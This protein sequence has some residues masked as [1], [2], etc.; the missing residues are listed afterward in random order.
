MSAFARIWPVPRVSLRASLVT[1]CI[2]V[3][4]PRGWKRECSQGKLVT[5]YERMPMPLLRVSARKLGTDGAA[6]SEAVGEVYEDVKEIPSRGGTITE[7]HTSACSR[8]ETTQTR[9]SG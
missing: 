4:S 1:T 2:F 7:G 5:T 9:T 3:A 6:A 8:R